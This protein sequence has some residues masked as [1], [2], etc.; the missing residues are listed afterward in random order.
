MPK[1]VRMADIA[2]RLGISI[3][4]VSKG[5]AG[6]DGVSEE[7]RAQIIATAKEMGYKMPAV[8]AK[9]GGSI[10]GG[11]IIGALVA[12][13]FFNENTFYSNMYRGIL[14]KCAAKG[15]SVAMEIVSLEAE[16]G[17][18]MPTLLVNHQVDALILMG[19]LERPYLQKVM[20]SGLP[21][22][23]LDFYQDDEAA[24]CILSDNVSGAYQLTRHLLETGR[25][26][27]AFVGSIGSTSSI[28]DRY[29]GYT[30]AL[31]RAGITP[32]ADWRLEDRD[33]DGLFLPFQLPAE[34]PDAFLC[35]CDEVA[36]NLITY[37]QS[38]GYRVPE[39]VAVAGYDDFRYALLSDPQITTYHV[40]VEAMAGA[41][42]DQLTQKMTGPK[43]VP[44][45]VI[46]PGKIVLRE[47]TAK[48]NA[49]I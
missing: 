25:R 17:C 38:Q 21:Y 30:K 23:L 7:M 24:D 11:Q 9:E 29:L 27:I 34:M 31:L 18:I 42:V 8:R 48:V 33:R 47:S 4:S 39:D 35:S 49:S 28:M 45:T 5:L 20:Q 3:V 16:R 37:L 12:D 19:E 13:H 14:Q 22:L 32:R 40:D 2:E 41:A 1:A 26:K 10:G 36:H 6:K 44:S 15:I 46:V 43:E